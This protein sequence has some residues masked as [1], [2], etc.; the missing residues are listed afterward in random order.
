MT[1]LK[2]KGPTH[3]GLLF[4]W[5]GFFEWQAYESE[6]S[7]CVFFIF[8]RSTNSDSDAEEI[9]CI[10][11]GR[12]GKYIVLADTDSDVTHLID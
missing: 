2:S 1:F 4:F 6:I 10:F 11:V 5:L 9:L 3:V 7:L 8:G 12:L